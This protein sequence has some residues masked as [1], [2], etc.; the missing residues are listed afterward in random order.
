[1]RRVLFV[2]IS[3]GIVVGFVAGTLLAMICGGAAAIFVGLAKITNS[4][5]SGNEW[6]AEVASAF[7]A[8]LGLLF[9]YTAGMGTA[10]GLILG[11]GLAMAERRKRPQ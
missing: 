5:F 4:E 9:P 1:M 11:I 8:V 2:K 7:R 10:L 3:G 6:I